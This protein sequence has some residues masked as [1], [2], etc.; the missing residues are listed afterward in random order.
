[1]PINQEM[2]KVAQENVKQADLRGSYLVG[3]NTA[4]LGGLAGAG[5]GGVYGL[6]SGAMGSRK[7]SR[8][9]DTLM[10][11]LRGAAGGGLLGAGAGA[12]FGATIGSY[13]PATE[14]IN[15]AKAGTPIGMDA[16]KAKL[17]G[18]DPS[19]A[20]GLTTLGTL[21]GAG[22]GGLV[23][24]ALLNQQKP[25]SKP[26]KDEKA[27]EAEKQ[28]ADSWQSVNLAK[29]PINW[30][31]VLPKA[32][33]TAKDWKS[34]G[35][36]W[37]GSALPNKSP[38]AP[39]AAPAMKPMPGAMKKS[40]FAFGQKAAAGLGN[41]NLSSLQKYLPGAGLGAGAGALVGGLGGLMFPGRR[42]GRLGGALRGALAGAGLGGLA[43]G[44]ASGGM[45]GQQAQGAMSDVY[46]RLGEFYTDKFNPKSRLQFKSQT[47]EEVAARAGEEPLGE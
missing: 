31:R 2:L 30:S 26:K 19:R 7:G 45:F 36:G 38:T 27:T 28:S 25:A 44:A 8:I 3:S 39:A 14:I 17:Q 23:G 4:S 12:G 13:I 18:V 37:M 1:M 47:P 22:L 5:L 34:A 40:A 32:D 10:G 20:A 11:G 33:A 6:A 24:G 21:G 29:N 35:G 41:F 42:R 43:G 46:K 16:L 15:S 9:K